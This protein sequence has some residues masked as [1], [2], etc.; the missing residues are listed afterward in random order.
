MSTQILTKPPTITVALK[1]ISPLMIERLHI[2]RQEIEAGQGQGEL[3]PEQAS[4]LY[5]V[6]QALG[7]T[8][9]ETLHVLGEKYLQWLDRPAAVATINVP[10]E[11]L[12]A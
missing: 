7:M 10:Q 9:S 6:C 3:T 5:D 2:L 8:E 11:L 12:N 4:L 1:Q